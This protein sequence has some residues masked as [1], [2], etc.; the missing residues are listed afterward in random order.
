MNVIRFHETLAK[1]IAAREGVEVK[2][3]VERKVDDERDKTI[4]TPTKRTG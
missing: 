1:L 2:V 4:S 3:T